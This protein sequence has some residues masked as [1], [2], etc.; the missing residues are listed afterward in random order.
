M[1]TILDKVQSGLQKLKTYHE[2]SS[3]LADREKTIKQLKIDLTFLNNIPPTPFPDAKECVLASNQ[4]I[5]SI[6]FRL[7]LAF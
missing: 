4:V 1:T 5:L 7:N 2:D 6:Y 3:T